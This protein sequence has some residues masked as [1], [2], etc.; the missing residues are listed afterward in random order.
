MLKEEETSCQGKM[1]L[2]LIQGKK[3]KRVAKSPKEILKGIERRVARE[4]SKA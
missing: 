3:I 1:I 4:T 2:P